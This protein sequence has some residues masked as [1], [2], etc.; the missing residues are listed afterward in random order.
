MNNEKNKRLPFIIG[1]SYLLSFITIRLMV[2]IAGSLKNETVIAIKE[3]AIPSKLYIGRNIIIYGYHIHHFYFVILLLSIA[4]WLAIVGNKNYSKGK[5]AVM[6]GVGLGLFMDEIGMLLTEG[7]YYSSLSYLLG[8][9][10]LGILINIVYFPP[11][12]KSVRKS[13]VNTKIPGVK[14]IKSLFNYI[15]KTLDFISSAIV[16][17]KMHILVIIIIFFVID[18]LI[19]YIF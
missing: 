4:G 2:I 14:I 9:L 19:P 5:L 17:Y 18:F 11:F 6:Y 16:K 10:L 3:G 13:F 1:S 8:V 15:I 12:W 7:Y